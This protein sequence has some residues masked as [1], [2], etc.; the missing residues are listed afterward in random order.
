MRAIQSD[1]ESAGLSQ[2]NTYY[3]FLTD[4]Y[5]ATNREG[6][7][8]RGRKYGYIYMGNAGS[9]QALSRVIAHELGHG[10]F[11]LEHTY[12]AYE[13]ELP[14]GQTDNLMDKGSGTRLYKWQWDLIHNPVSPPWLEGDEEGESVGEFA[15]ADDDFSNPGLPEDSNYSSC[16]FYKTTHNIFVK[17]SNTVLASS[18]PNFGNNG[19]LLSITYGGKTYTVCNRVKDVPEQPGIVDVTTGPLFVNM[20]LKDGFTKVTR[21]DRQGNDVIVLTPTPESIL[22]FESQDYC[23]PEDVGKIFSYRTIGGECA[24]YT[25]PTVIINDYN[26]PL[27]LEDIEGLK[28]LLLG[29]T[30]IETSDGFGNGFT[31]HTM[32]A[33]IVIS[34]DDMPGS[35]DWAKNYQST[36]GPE[37][38]KIWL[39]KVGENWTIPADFTWPANAQTFFGLDPSYSSSG[40]LSV[41]GSGFKSLTK[42]MYEFLDMVEKGLEYIKIPE[43]VW[44]CDKEGY[45]ETYATIYGYIMAPAN[46]PIKA[47]GN[48]LSDVLGGEFA[49]QWNS[50][51]VD[52]YQFAFVCGAWNAVVDVFKTIPAILKWV[53]DPVGEFGNFQ[54]M[55]DNLAKMERLKADGSQ[56]CS[57]YWCLLYEIKD[58]F[59]FFSSPCTALHNSAGIALGV[60]CA[61]LTG[62]AGSGVLASTSA[63]RAILTIAKILNRVDDLTDVLG[64]SFKLVNKI[65]SGVRLR[66]FDLGPDYPLSKL[67]TVSDDGMV[68]LIKKDGSTIDIDE[69]NFNSSKLSTDADGKIYYND[70]GQQ[71]ELKA[72][73]AT[74]FN[75]NLN[76]SGIHLKIKN[77]LDELFLEGKVTISP[78][79]NSQAIKY[80]K[81]PNDPETTVGQVQNNGGNGEFDIDNNGNPNDQILES[82]P[83][84][85]IAIVQDGNT[86][87]LKACG[88]LAG[89]TAIATPNGLV[90][91]EQLEVGDKILAPEQSGKTAI[92]TITRIVE[93]AAVKMK[94]IFSGGSSFDFTYGHPVFVH[95]LGR[96]ISVDSLK[97]GMRLLTLSGLLLTIDSIAAVQYSTAVYDLQT[98]AGTG[99]FAGK[100]EIFV[101]NSS[102]NFILTSLGFDADQIVAIKNMIEDIEILEL[103]L[104]DVAN[105]QELRDF[106]KA[107]Q[108]VDFDKKLNV[109]NTFSSFNSDSKVWIRKSVALIEKLANS[110]P[111]VLEKVKSYYS[112]HSKAKLPNNDSPTPAYSY[113]TTSGHQVEFDDYGQARFE[114]HVPS[115]SGAGKVSYNPDEILAGGGT[116]PQGAQATLSGNSSSDISDARAWF[117]Q[118]HPGDVE[119]VGSSQIKIK[120]NSSPFADENGWV[121]CVLHHHEDGRNIIP[122]PTVVHN[123]DL[124]GASHTGGASAIKKGI[125]DFFDPL[126]F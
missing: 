44:N 65:T 58:Q 122:V 106:F 53:V 66:V 34:S 24:E 108:G 16:E 19:A 73:K 12:E 113:T 94:R 92:A 67:G 70:N 71:I 50:G 32:K 33:F 77:K 56:E 115:I 100:E 118:S 18:T 9:G 35:Y 107:A 38:R 11:V 80:K 1:F 125:K 82:T 39:H 5:E 119:L 85:E 40:L 90:P 3:L 88:C 68:S 6:F 59:N 76:F 95:D 60:V 123:R 117:I 120:D 61:V 74:G 64:Q 28:E 97:T 26:I 13:S 37:F 75:W 112:S 102:C 25:C 54:K 48:S 110:A 83:D 121:T 45:D 81:N 89:S 62:G 42:G 30:P 103:F 17:F 15:F 87:K 52:K 23:K 49:N 111:D 86:K 98:D 114:P 10:A 41:L 31:R 84:G 57:G 124:G 79:G 27:T 126:T 20:E 43:Y 2:S 8:P 46:A 7:M 91:L 116:L 29:N 96:K 51:D 109:W 4:D 99:Y 72:R 104:N 105:N 47:M 63:G 101:V 21:Q 55:L 69:A 93:S 14:E 36:F 78:A 22:S